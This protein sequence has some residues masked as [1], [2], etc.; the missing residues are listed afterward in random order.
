MGIAFRLFPSVL[1]FAVHSILPFV[2]IGRQLDLESTTAFLAER[3]AWLETAKT[4]VRFA[5]PRSFA[6][7]DGANLV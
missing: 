7:S 4:T 5:G 2:P 1:A 6:A 3:N